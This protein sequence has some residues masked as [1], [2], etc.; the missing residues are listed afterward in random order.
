MKTSNHSSKVHKRR[1]LPWVFTRVVP[2][3]VEKDLRDQAKTT[4][5]LQERLS[6]PCMIVLINTSSNNFS[7]IQAIL[8]FSL[9]LYL[10]ISSSAN[11]W[12]LQRAWALQRK[13]FKRYTTQMRITQFNSKIALQPSWQSKICVDRTISR[14]RCLLR[15]TPCHLTWQRPSGG[16]TGHWLCSSWSGRFSWPRVECVDLRSN[17]FFLTREQRPMTGSNR[18]F[19]H[20]RSVPEWRP[21]HAWLREIWQISIDSS[22]MSARSPFVDFKSAIENN[23]RNGIGLH[24]LLAL[25]IDGFGI[26]MQK[27]AGKIRSRDHRVDMIEIKEVKSDEHTISRIQSQRYAIQRATALNLI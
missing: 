13:Y 15:A 2:S 23:F 16:P 5:Y 21:A 24:S 7:H 27:I 4:I 12:L 25:D 17:H 3:L 10:Q 22:S 20:T 11:N 18:L 19:C 8:I 1:A 9:E 14:S 6:D 26:D